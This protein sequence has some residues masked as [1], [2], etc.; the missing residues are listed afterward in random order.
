MRIIGVILFVTFGVFAMP[1]DWWLH[2]WN[3][4]VEE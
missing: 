1:V 2:E 3:A 4:P